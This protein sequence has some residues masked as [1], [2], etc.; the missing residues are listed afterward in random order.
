MADDWTGTVPGGSSAAPPAAPGSPR[1]S[2]PTRPDMPSSPP[3]HLT[4]ALYLDKRENAGH[5]T[6]VIIYLSTEP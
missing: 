4:N 1:P 5:Y 3:R 2:R 6:E